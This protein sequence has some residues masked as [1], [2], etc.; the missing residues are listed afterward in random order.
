MLILLLARKYARYLR[1]ELLLWTLLLVIQAVFI[2]SELQS[3]SEEV[4]GRT[5]AHLVLNIS[6]IV[7][8]GVITVQ[9]VQSDPVTGSTAFWMT[10][11]ISR[12]GLFAAKLVFALLTVVV[13]PMLVSGAL[14]VALGV[15]GGAVVPVVLTVVAWQLCLMA[16]V[17]LVASIT[18]GF[19]RFLLVGAV[20]IVGVSG[21]ATYVGP[22]LRDY[23]L[24]GRSSM[25]LV[26]T[27]FWVLLVLTTALCLG[28]ALY[29]HIRMNLRR[30]VG[31]TVLAALLLLVVVSGWPWDL[32]ARP[33]MSVDRGAL[34]PASVA[35]SLD[36]ATKIQ[37]QRIFLSYRRERPTLRLFGGFTY[38][39]TPQGIFLEPTRVESRLRFAGGPEITTRGESRMRPWNKPEALGSQDLIIR[40]LGDGPW[41]SLSVPP[42]HGLEPVLAEVPEA[43]YS[44]HAREAGVYSAVVALDAYRWQL[45]AELPLRAGASCRLNPGRAV[46]R[47]IGRVGNVYQ[48]MLSEVTVVN[49]ARARSRMEGQYVLR[50]R[51]R[52]QVL[53]PFAITVPAAWDPMVFPLGSQLRVLH[54]FLRVRNPAVDDAWLAEAD[55]VRIEPVYLGQFTAPLR[56]D[57]LVLSPAS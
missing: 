26:D 50:N 15:A 37:P 4:F 55:L 38:A 40:A 42:G 36:P 3:S 43:A 12:V 54:T 44:Q 6:V 8:M 1:W 22:P 24:R 27:Q 47:E 2:G 25:T 19:A 46:F 49:T 16:V 31:L 30:T 7:M 52:R 10:K 39:G 45:R 56:V 57:N 18:A 21:V 17:F 11:P 33:S 28:V 32:L 51:T 35:L 14:A 9:L 23:A 48:V 53:F 20:L 34:N 5:I 41:T 13:L 29:Q